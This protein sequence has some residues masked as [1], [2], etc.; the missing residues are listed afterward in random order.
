MSSTQAV[1]E[2]EASTPQVPKTYWHLQSGAWD[3]MV[4]LLDVLANHFGKTCD[5]VA[6]IIASDISLIDILH[7]DWN[8][9]FKTQTALVESA[10]T[11]WTQSY[12]RPKYREEHA[13]LKKVR[14]EHWE[15]TEKYPEEAALFFSFFPFNEYF[16]QSAT[17]TTT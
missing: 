14:G 7:A 12:L 9:K 5:E 10:L 17:T 4:P 13:L 3:H 6:E 2:A 15:P 8:S 11:E 16:T 1:D